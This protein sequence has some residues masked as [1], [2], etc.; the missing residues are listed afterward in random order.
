MTDRSASPSPDRSSD[1]ADTSLPDPD[2]FLPRDDDDDDFLPDPYEDPTSLQATLD[3]IL[4][5]DQL[6]R[7][8]RSKRALHEGWREAPIAFL[9]T[10]KYDIGTVGLFDSSEKKRAPSWCDRVLYRTRRDLRGLP[11]GGA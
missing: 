5:H 10:Y 4:P 3:S 8:M 1:T 2:D 6:Y 9:P 11:R 7:L